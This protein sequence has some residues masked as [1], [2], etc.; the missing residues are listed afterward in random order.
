M[1][2]RK[3]VCVCVRACEEAHLPPFPPLPLL[4]CLVL[5]AGFHFWLFTT[6]TPFFF[7]W[8]SLA[9]KHTFARTSTHS[10]SRP[11]HLALSISAPSHA[12]YTCD[13]KATFLISLGPFP[14]PFL[15]SLCASMLCWLKRAMSNACQRALLISTF[16]VNS[17]DTG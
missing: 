1:R 15:P 3:C 2:G 4:A 9:G 13:F 10:L 6:S 14:T 12:D 11:A 7:S 17:N 8:L 5:S 16:D